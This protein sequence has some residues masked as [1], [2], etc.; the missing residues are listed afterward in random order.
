MIKIHVN[1]GRTIELSKSTE[2]GMLLNVD[3]LDSNGEVDYSY[4]I[5]ESEIVT[6]LNQF[7]REIATEI[8]WEE[9]REEKLLV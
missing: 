2:R 3:V 9:T 1:N 4:I 6:L 7:E 8:E 5:S